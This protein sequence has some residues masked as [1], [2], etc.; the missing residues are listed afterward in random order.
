MLH[1]ADL[2][3]EQGQQTVSQEI[4][5]TVNQASASADAPR[6]DYNEV[7]TSQKVSLCPQHALRLLCA[8]PPDLRNL[9]QVHH[10]NM[11]DIH[12]EG[13]AHSDPQQVWCSLPEEDAHHVCSSVKHMC[14][15]SKH[16]SWLHLHLL[17][18]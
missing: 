3:Q 10:Q 8:L 5:W 2:V 9:F 15:G 13:S 18:N 14:P 6:A 12:A 1:K 16:D 4:D 7:P 17:Q 11:E